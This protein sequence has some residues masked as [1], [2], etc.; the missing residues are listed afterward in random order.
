MANM[1]RFNVVV[2]SKYIGQYGRN[3]ATAYAVADRDRANSIVSQKYDSQL[4]AQQDAD[5]LNAGC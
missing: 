3:S 1:P 4:A 2:V 5:R